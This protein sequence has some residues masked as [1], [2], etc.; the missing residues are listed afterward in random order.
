MDEGDAGKRRNNSGG[1]SLRFL[2]QLAVEPFR[3][4]I[5]VGFCK[6]RAP[7]TSRGWDGA[8]ETLHTH[9]KAPLGSKGSGC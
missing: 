5:R 2:P 7:N 1:K 3:A 4:G 8:R 9:R 6:R